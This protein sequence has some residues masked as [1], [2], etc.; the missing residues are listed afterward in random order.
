M[1]LVIRRIRLTGQSA[2]RGAVCDTELNIAHS[3]PF[4]DTFAVRLLENGVTLETVS[5]LF[6]HS[7]IKITERHY[8]PWVQTLQANL[9][10]AAMKAWNDQ[11]ELHSDCATQEASG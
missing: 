1:V 2:T 3:H 6:G 9:E 7:S 4:R 5:I 8:R 11:L 10:A